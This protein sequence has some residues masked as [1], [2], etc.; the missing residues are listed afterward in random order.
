[1]WN[2]NWIETHAIVN[3]PKLVLK[4]DLDK[5]Q[6]IRD[7]RVQTGAIEWVQ[8]ILRLQNIILSFRHVYHQYNYEVNGLSKAA[9]SCPLDVLQMEKTRGGGHPP[10]NP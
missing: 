4:I 3:I 7:S 5:L 6:L 10:T 8:W 9:N 1:M 2:N